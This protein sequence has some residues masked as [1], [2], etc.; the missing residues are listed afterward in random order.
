MR[1]AGALSL[2]WACFWS[3]KASGRTKL[4]NALCMSCTLA[5]MTGELVL[6]VIYDIMVCAVGETTATF[7]VPGV[8]EH[9]YFMK[10]STLAKPPKRSCRHETHMSALP[11]PLPLLQQHRS[12]P[13]ALT[14]AGRARRR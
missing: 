11:A 5:A 1:M 3:H 7:G 14:W 6:Q 10:A 12:E 2:R 8:M 13:A 4:A 9:C